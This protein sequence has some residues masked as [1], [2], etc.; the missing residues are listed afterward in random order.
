MNIIELREHLKLCF[1]IILIFEVWSESLCSNRL[2][3]FVVVLQLGLVC[4]GPFPH[5]RS[6]VAT[7]QRPQRIMNCCGRCAAGT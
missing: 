6:S 7:A 5:L 3:V 4:K 2:T 1:L